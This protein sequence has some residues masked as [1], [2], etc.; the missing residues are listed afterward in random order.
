MIPR[1]TSLLQTTE[2]TDGQ[3][4]TETRSW[5]SQLSQAAISTADLLTKL[6]LK[7]S[8]FSAQ[9]VDLKPDFPLRVP[10]SFIAKMRRGD[11]TDPLL[12]QV[13]PLG[14]ENQN[15]PGFS[16]DPLGEGPAT[17]VP[18]LLHKYRSRALLITSPA[19]AIHCRYCFR[20]HFPYQDNRP[21]KSNWQAAV[22]YVT[23]H[24]E[25]NELILSGGDPLAASDRHLDELLSALEAIPHLKRIRWHS[26]L[27]VVLPD[28]ICHSW[29]D[30]IKQSPLR[31][32]M[33][34][35]SNHAQELGQ[36][37]AGACSRMH[38]AGISLLNQTVLLRGI[39]DKTDILSALSERLDDLGVRPYYL[40]VLDRVD[41]AAHFEVDEAQAQWLMAELQTLLPGFL[42]PI[43]VREEAG[44]D[45]KTR[46]PAE[47][48]QS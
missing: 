29:L 9:G 24:P 20:R 43:L 35:H 48:N 14:L 39:N 6:G 7:A 21:S 15:T 30:R 33:V 42:V 16:A 12:L 46:L 13:L 28:R 2:L 18:G 27:P 22:S 8:D 31:H 26:R 37:V 11:P 19:C 47:P 10:S 38:T 5:Q 40:H 25:I 36:D 23:E 41:G 4:E 3:L 32:Y 17:A 44:R 1:T 34:I 45:H